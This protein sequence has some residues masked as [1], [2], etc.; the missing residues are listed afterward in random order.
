MRRTSA[1]VVH[2]VVWVSKPHM[3][4]W[5]VTAT[6]VPSDSKRYTN[7]LKIS[8]TKN[9]AIREYT[10]I[11]IYIYIYIEYPSDLVVKNYQ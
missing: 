2:M 8:N 11:Y 5:T 6:R 4:V 10:Y 7:Y 3:V 9:S 1:A